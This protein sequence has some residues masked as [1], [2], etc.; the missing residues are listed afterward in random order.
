MTHVESVSNGTNS[1]RTPG[2][3]SETNFQG[4]VKVRLVGQSASL[5]IDPNSDPKPIS[6]NVSVNEFFKVNSP[7]KSPTYGLLLLLELL[8]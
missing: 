4:K 6:H 3:D 8:N 5:R 7:T 1:G 2:R